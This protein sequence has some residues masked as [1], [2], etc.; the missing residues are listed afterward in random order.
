MTWWYVGWTAL[1]LAWVIGF[2][3][4]EGWAIKKGGLTLS[5]Y[6]WILSQAWGPMPFVLGLIV[7]GLAVHFYWH[8]M[9]P[10][11]RSVG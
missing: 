6:T 7:G 1:N 3:V 4:L 5:M 10:G 9:P 2:A 8:W 11:A